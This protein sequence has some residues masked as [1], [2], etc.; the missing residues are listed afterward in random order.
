M[1]SPCLSEAGGAVGFTG[2]Y[3]EFTGIYW[4]LLPVDAKPQ[5]PP[6][7]VQAVGDGH[8]AQQQQQDS[9]SQWDPDQGTAG[10]FPAGSFPFGCPWQ[11]LFGH[12]CLRGLWRQSINHCE[13]CPSAQ[14]E[15]GGLGHG[16]VV[17]AAV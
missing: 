5:P 13:L 8:Q 12:W 4:E 9:S 17:D 14:E 6:Q 16:A 1:A 10:T 15:L 3:W 11:R 7:T 2:I